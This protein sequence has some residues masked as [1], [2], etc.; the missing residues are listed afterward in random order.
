M[1]RDRADLG[2]LVGGEVVEHDDIARLQRGH[3]DLR[4]VGTEGDGVDRTIEPGM[5]PAVKSARIRIAS[6]EVPFADMM[7]RTAATGVR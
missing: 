3:Q 1:N 7:R 2:S 5:P 6:N 4:H